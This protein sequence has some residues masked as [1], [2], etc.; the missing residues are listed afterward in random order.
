M[1]VAPVQVMLMLVTCFLLLLL[2]VACVLVQAD[3]GGLCVLLLA[4]VGGLC[5]VQTDFGGRAVF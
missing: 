3:V 5:S 2:F 4:D 1:L